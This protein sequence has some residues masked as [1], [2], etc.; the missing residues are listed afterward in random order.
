LA[1]WH[2]SVVTTTGNHTCPHIDEEGIIQ[3]AAVDMEVVDMA[4][5]D[6][7]AVDVRDR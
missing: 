2:I 6:I 1:W 3:E 4:E 5:V 7:A